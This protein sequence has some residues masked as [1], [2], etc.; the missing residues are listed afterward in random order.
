M[1]LS[2]TTCNLFTYQKDRMLKKL[3]LHDSLSIIQVILIFLSSSTTTI[4]LWPPID[5]LVVTQLTL[6]K[7]YG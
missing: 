4:L 2:F 7:H 6:K 3:H 1:V 5:A